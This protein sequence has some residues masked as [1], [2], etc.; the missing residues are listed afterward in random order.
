[1]TRA[2]T[3][4][5]RKRLIA[6]S[7]KLELGC[8][9][10]LSLVM[11]ENGASRKAPTGSKPDLVGSI[12]AHVHPRDAVL[13]LVRFHVGAGIKIPG[14]I[15]SVQIA[16]HVFPR[17]GRESVDEKNETADRGAN[18]TKDTPPFHDA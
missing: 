17:V 3:P 16:C 9:V 6:P 14:F 10:M 15:G 18:D 7:F 2:A 8:T 11:H 12:V 5:V 1:M 4:R 13:Y